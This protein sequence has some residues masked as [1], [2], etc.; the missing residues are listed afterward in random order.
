M[1]PNTHFACRKGL[2]TCQALLCVSHT[3]QSTLE[4]GKKAGI[5]QIDFSAATDKV[6]LEGIIYKIHSVG[7]RGLVLSILTQFLSNRSH[8]VTVDGCLSKLFHFV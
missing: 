6:N 1:L 5:V 3:L 4:C 7:I 2:G 8:H